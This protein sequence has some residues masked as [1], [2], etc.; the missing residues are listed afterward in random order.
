[1]TNDKKQMFFLCS[2]LRVHVCSPICT[3]IWFQFPGHCCFLLWRPVKNGGVI[4]WATEVGSQG[5]VYYLG[6]LYY[7]GG[8][9][10]G[11]FRGFSTI[12]TCFRP[13]A[14][15]QNQKFICPLQFRAGGGEGPT[16]S[17]FVPSWKSTALSGLPIH[18]CP[19]RLSRHRFFFYRNNKST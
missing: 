14:G 15:P 17:V 16:P 1:M 13:F 3:K 19:S 7:L 8:I 10:F 6:G 18:H 5:G 12:L 2:P 11:G 9:L 4:T